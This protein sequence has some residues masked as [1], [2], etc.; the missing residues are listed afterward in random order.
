MDPKALKE[1]FRPI[2]YPRSIAVVGAANDD[3]KFGT[4]YLRAL[5]IAGYQGKLYAINP[6]ETGVLGLPTYPTVRDIPE[7]VEY[8]IMAVPK[9]FAPAIFDD[10]AARGV[11]VVQMFTAG[12]RETGREEDRRLEDEL[13]RKA[14]EGGFHIVGPNCI[15]VY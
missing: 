4:R 13:V 14:Q 3:R 1:K 6:Y 8:V 5:L 11:K 2:F 7:P 10:C 15:G 9:R 12:F